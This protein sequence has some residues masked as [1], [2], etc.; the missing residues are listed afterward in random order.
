[1]LDPSKQH[2]RSHKQTLI[3]S[4]ALFNYNHYSFFYYTSCHNER[5]ETEARQKNANPD[6]AS[7]LAVLPDILY[8]EPYDGEVAIEWETVTK[9]LNLLTFVDV[10]AIQN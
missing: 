4:K 5:I 2:S 10:S 3:F 6:C 8:S 7:F 9:R 1:M